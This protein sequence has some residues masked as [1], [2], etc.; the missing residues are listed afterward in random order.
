M[1]L[2]E[3]PADPPPQTPASRSIEDVLNLSDAMERVQGDRQLLAELIHLF[4]DDLPQRNQAMKQ[5]LDDLDAKALAGAAHGLKGCLANLGAAGAF[6]LAILL[7]ES[8][9][10][11]ELGRAQELWG[12]LNVELGRLQEALKHVEP[13]HLPS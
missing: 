8:A 6:E 1:G 11:G 9:A 10:S 12:D 3:P 4:L 5:A 2:E 13:E 7:E